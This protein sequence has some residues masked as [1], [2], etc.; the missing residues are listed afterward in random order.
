MSEQKTIRVKLTWD[1]DSDGEYD[2][3]KVEVY[4]YDPVMIIA[5]EH[6]YGLIITPKEAK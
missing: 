1:D 5:N 2:V 4:T 3:T 6:G